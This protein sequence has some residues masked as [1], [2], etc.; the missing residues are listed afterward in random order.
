VSFTVYNDVSTTEGTQGQYTFHKGYHKH[1]KDGYQNCIKDD[2]KLGMYAML[3]DSPPDDDEYQLEVFKTAD[4]CRKDNRNQGERVLKV[5]WQVVSKSVG[6][7]EAGENQRMRYGDAGKDGAIGYCARINLQLSK[8]NA[9]RVKCDAAMKTR[10]TASPTSSPTGFPSRA[11]D[12]LSD[13][14]KCQRDAG[15]DATKL[16]ACL[17]TYN[18]DKNSGVLC[19]SDCTDALELYNSDGVDIGIKDASGNRV[20]TKCGFSCPEEE[21]SNTGTIIAI[22]IGVL[23][24]LIIIAVVVVMMKR[25]KFGEA[26]V[27]GP[28]L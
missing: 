7:L 17:Q 11:P 2:G 16:C 9:G 13:E 24:L 3:G 22:V 19:G 27:G 10:T 8:G 15:K 26:P 20:L 4:D 12:F 5:D 28:D 25:K 6:N 18:I 21:S 14:R 1:T 23:V